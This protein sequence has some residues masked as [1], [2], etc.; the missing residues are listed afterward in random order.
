MAYSEQDTP[1]HFLPRPPSQP[2]ADSDLRAVLTQRTL[3]GASGSLIV[4]FVPDILPHHTP[5]HNMTC[6]R[7]SSSRPEAGP[8]RSARTGTCCLTPPTI[9]PASQRE[10]RPLQLSTPTFQQPRRDTRRQRRAVREGGVTA[11]H[12][13]GSPDYWVGKRPQPTPPAV[14]AA[15]LEL[16]PDQGP[17]WEKGPST[18]SRKQR[19]ELHTGTAL[20]LYKVLG[21][22]SGTGAGHA[23]ISTGAIVEGVVPRRHLEFSP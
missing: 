20:R 1:G 22:A 19:T 17:A 4:D 18:P 10:Q 13:A 8:G 6:K 9:L 7:F 21:W 12:R 5:S 23:A 15:G 3:L 16:R 11:T 2:T 14:L